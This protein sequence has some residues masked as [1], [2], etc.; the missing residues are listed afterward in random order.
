MNASELTRLHRAK[1]LASSTDLRMPHTTGNVLLERAYGA[2][3][4]VFMGKEIKGPCCKTN[5]TGPPENLALTLTFDTT[6]RSLLLDIP[7]VIFATGGGGFIDLGDGTLIQWSEMYEITSINGPT[8]KVYSSDI[9]IIG[10][11]GGL[12]TNVSLHSPYLTQ[13]NTISL[14][15]TEGSGA[16]NSIALVD[17][18]QLADVTISNQM[19]TSINLTGLPAITSL[20]LSQNNLTSLDISPL[21]ALITLSVGNNFL[22]GIDLLANSVL[23]NLTISNNNLDQSAADAIAAMLIANGQHDGNLFIKDQIGGTLNTSGEGWDLLVENGWSIDLLPDI[24][25][26]I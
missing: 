2:Q 4:V 12:L 9:K 14:G 19:L 22:T 23:T 10:Y 8:V 25:P 15:G 24:D 13:L 5:S 26:E 11:D 6:P 3:S 16:I 17:L 21:T 1:I 7:F 18:P 20:S